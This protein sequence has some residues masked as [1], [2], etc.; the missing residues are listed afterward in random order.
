MMH[1][2]Y[3][4]FNIHVNFLK[5]ACIGGRDGHAHVTKR[6]KHM[7]QCVAIKQGGERGQGQEKV[8]L[9]IL[10]TTVKV[11]ATGHNLVP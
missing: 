11:P 5:V 1:S 4:N 3:G 10:W 8:P 6:G 7:Y 9:F 2:S